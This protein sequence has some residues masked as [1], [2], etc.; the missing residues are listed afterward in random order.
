M[1]DNL[2]QKSTLTYYVETVLPEEI[3]SIR[4]QRPTVSTSMTRLL[5]H[6]A[7]APRIVSILLSKYI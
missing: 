2:Q 6:D 1:V 5:I 3:K 7:R 4:Q